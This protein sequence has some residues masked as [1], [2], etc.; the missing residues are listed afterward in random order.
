MKSITSSDG[1]K[2]YYKHLD[3][4]RLI[5]LNTNLCM[6]PILED[7]KKFLHLKSLDAAHNL[8]EDN[9][10][11]R[12]LLREYES[13]CRKYDWRPIKI[14]QDGNCGL[15]APDGKQLLPP[16]FRDAFNQ[17]DAFDTH[18]RFIPVFNGKGWAIVNLG[19]SPIL[20][21]DFK[22]E[23][24]IPERWDKEIFFVQDSKTHK[25]GALSTYSSHTNMDISYIRLGGIKEI[26]PCI[27]E[28]IFENQLITECAPTLFFITRIGDKIGILT[29]FGYSKIE[30]DNY[31]VNYEN[32]TFCM[33]QKAHKRTNKVDI[34]TYESI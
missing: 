19:E 15:N 2:C 14:Y 24:I 1:Q 8:N 9:L 22:Y 11:E 3:Y 13:Y 10:K 32:M 6:I 28:E 25:W 4:W 33:I 20:M 12:L 5:R 17:F 31:D 30:Y 23:T 34:I 16:V 21:T 29:P 7:A 26:M 18:V 27:A